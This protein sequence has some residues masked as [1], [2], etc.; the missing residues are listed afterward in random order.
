MLGWQKSVLYCPSRSNVR[1]LPFGLHSGYWRVDI[2]F[3]V[4]GLVLYPSALGLSCVPRV[5][6]VL[7]LYTQTD[8]PLPILK[9]SFL[10]TS[11]PRGLQ[12]TLPGD[13]QAPIWCFRT[14]FWCTTNNWSTIYDVPTLP[15]SDLQFVTGDPPV[16]LVRPW[17][18]ETVSLLTSLV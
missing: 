14:P 15:L 6:R 7:R 11:F 3:P 4:K 12:V 18:R 8:L 5:T 17:D 13:G 2:Q 1:T 16:L 9:L 10:D